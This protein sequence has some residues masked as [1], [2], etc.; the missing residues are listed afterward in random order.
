VK[1][2]VTWDAASFAGSAFGSS[3]SNTAQGVPNAAVD[4]SEPV[5]AGAGLRQQAALHEGSITVQVDHRSSGVTATLGRGLPRRA[6]SLRRSNSMGETDMQVPS[7]SLVTSLAHNAPKQQR[8]LQLAA[9]AAA[10]AACS[11]SGPLC[12]SCYCRGEQVTTSHPHPAAC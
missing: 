5:Q 4:S 11:A 1:K 12:C 2:S 6:F 9:A 10:A 7:A 3:S 8:S